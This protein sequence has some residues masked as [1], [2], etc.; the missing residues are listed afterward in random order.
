MRRRNWATPFRMPMTGK[1]LFLLRRLQGI[2]VGGRLDFP[3]SSD[4]GI[5]YDSIV[6]S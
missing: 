6:L 2:E 3:G 1:Q 5:F 4:A